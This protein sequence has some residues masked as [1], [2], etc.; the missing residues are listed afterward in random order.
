MQENVNSLALSRKVSE[1]VSPSPYP[2]LVWGP[3]LDWLISIFRVGLRECLWC[4]VGC[5]GLS[6]CTLYGHVPQCTLYTP[7]PL[8]HSFFPL[9]LAEVFKLLLG[10]INTWPHTEWDVLEHICSEFVGEE[11]A[12]YNV[13]LGSSGGKHKCGEGESNLYRWVLNVDR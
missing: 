3:W 6:Q 2:T 7:P 8:S 13:G 10:A 4:T 1:T 5:T 11:G 9:C 12:R